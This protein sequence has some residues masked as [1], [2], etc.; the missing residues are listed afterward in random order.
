MFVVLPSR[1]F[2]LSQ[3]MGEVLFVIM[4]ILFRFLNYI[5]TRHENITMYMSRL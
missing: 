3:R 2:C 4:V 1:N 5:Y